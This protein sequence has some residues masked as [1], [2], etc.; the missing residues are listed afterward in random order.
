MYRASWVWAAA[1]PLT[2]SIVSCGGEPA[3]PTASTPTNAAD[4]FDARIDCGEAEFELD[5]YAG[6][7][8]ESGNRGC[9][10]S[11]PATAPEYD[12]RVTFGGFDLE[13]TVGAI[14]Q[15]V[16]GRVQSA[17]SVPVQ[18][19]GR[20]DLAFTV[21]DALGRVSE[22]STSIEWWWRTGPAQRGWTAAFDGGPT[23]SFGTGLQ[24][25]FSGM[26]TAMRFKTGSPTPPW[27]LRQPAEIIE[28]LEERLSSGIEAEWDFGDGTRESVT[29]P[30]TSSSWPDDLDGQTVP[31]TRGHT[32]QTPGTYTVTVTLTDPVWDRTASATHTV[33]ITGPVTPTPTPGPASLSDGVRVAV[34]RVTG[35]VELVAGQWFGQVTG[36]I[37]NTNLEQARIDSMQ[38]S[39]S[40]GL[41]S[42]SAVL[43]YDTLEPGETTPFRAMYLL[44]EGAPPAT[45]EGIAS[46][47]VQPSD[48]VVDRSLASQVTVESPT[49]SDKPDF[50]TYRYQGVVA[51]VNDSGQCLRVYVRAVVRD[52]G[53]VIDLRSVSFTG[54]MAAGRRVVA[55]WGS[56]IAPVD[57]EIVPIATTGC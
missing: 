49:L 53:D 1:I 35:A 54:S 37:T 50:G 44:A 2:F 21:E 4:G 52:D 22:A 39:L 51:L 20:Y 46:W 27:K 41:T 14:T 45:V 56:P 30:R 17:V 25:S 26:A 43:L 3:A 55:A 16:G 29:L 24:A 38:F 18:P 57:V 9:W 32:Y 10:L 7:E 42:R 13:T 5:L 19:P 6:I 15:V 11:W 28:L 40:G 23:S 31:F 12:L 48:A 36:E 47:R 33:D 34:H 8:D